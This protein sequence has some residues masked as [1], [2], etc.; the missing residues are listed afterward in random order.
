MT[1]QMYFR[2]SVIAYNTSNTQHESEPTNNAYLIYLCLRWFYIRDLGSII[3]QPFA[4]KA[5]S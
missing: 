3:I 4:P 1:Q 5:T 2:P